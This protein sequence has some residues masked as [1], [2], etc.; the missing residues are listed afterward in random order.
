[1][2]ARKEPLITGEYYH[3]FNRGVEHRLI[4]SSKRDYQRALLA[5]HYYRFANLP[6]KLSRYLIYS[7]QQ[8]EAFFERSG[9]N[10]KLVEVL[11]FCFMPNH[12][13][14]LLNQ[15]KDMGISK[16]LGNFQNSYT[17]FFNT[18]YDRDGHLFKGQFKAVRVEKDEQLMHLSRYIHLNPYTSHIIKNINDLLDY[19]WSSFPGYVDTKMNVLSNSNQILS[20][21]KTSEKYRDFVFDLADYQRKINDQKHILLE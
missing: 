13:H 11:C 3:V 12:F 16:F 14:F 9:H 6:V 19:E 20:Y 15:K 7:S 18:K 1:M 5:I 2:P 10:E 8:R 4:F 17:R 21:F